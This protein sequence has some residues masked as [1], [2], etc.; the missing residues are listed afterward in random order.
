MSTLLAD[1][2]YFLGARPSVADATVFA[3]L[4]G[5]LCL[6]FTTRLRSHGET[7]PNLV[8]YVAG[9]KAEFYPGL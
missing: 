9:M 8:A 3:F 4:I 2:R 5:V 1:N 7:L 6:H